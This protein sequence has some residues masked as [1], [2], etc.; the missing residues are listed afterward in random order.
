M[1]QCGRIVEYVVIEHVVA[2]RQQV[3]PVTGFG[4]LK[5]AALVHVLILEPHKRAVN[6]APVGAQELD[7]ARLLDVQVVA[8]NVPEVGV[9]GARVLGAHMAGVGIHIELHE[10]APRLV[11]RHNLQRGAPGLQV[12]RIARGGGPQKGN[13]AVARPNLWVAGGQRRST[14]AMRRDALL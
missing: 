7:I 14:K 6:A 10:A 1:R 9:H 4:H 5:Q 8:Q 11:L 13:H 3:H 12:G 2:H